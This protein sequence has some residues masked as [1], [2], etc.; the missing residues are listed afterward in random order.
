MT[1]FKEFNDTFSHPQAYLNIW[2]GKLLRLVDDRGESS[3]NFTVGHLV[4][5]AG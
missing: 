2:L 4:Q 5:V 1:F 3:K